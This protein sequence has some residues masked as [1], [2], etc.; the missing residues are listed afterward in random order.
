MSQT[1][2]VY[3]GTFDPIT[4]GHADIIQRASRIFDQLV[5][6][7]AA[8]P[9]KS[10][11]FTLE[12]RVDLVRQVIKPWQ[13]CRVEPFSALLVDF[14]RNQGA[15]VVLRGLRAVSD[16]EFEFQLSGIN[17]ALAPDVETLFLPTCERFAY[18]SSS[19]VREVASY[20]GDVSQFVD[21][22]VE[23][24]LTARFPTKPV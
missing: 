14:V 23:Q 1:I 8:N 3:P 16:F 15:T 2:A 18:L 21:P 20:E 17:R 7:V 24:A 6:A 9:G 19:L 10:P 22:V 5:V 4:N 11:A 12:E 13:N